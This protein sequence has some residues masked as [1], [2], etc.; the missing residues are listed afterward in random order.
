[1]LLQR[2][3][4]L[5]ISHVSIAQQSQR[6]RVRGGS[7]RGFQIVDRPRR[8]VLLQCCASGKSRCLGVSRNPTEIFSQNDLGRVRLT[9]RQPRYPLE[10]VSPRVSRKRGAEAI[11]RPFGRDVFPLFHLLQAAQ[12]VRDEI[13]GG[14]LQDGI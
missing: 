8:A 7:A 11:Q 3:F 13:V 2:Q 12:I 5:A 9:E 1:E 4:G 6:L 14:R 10:K